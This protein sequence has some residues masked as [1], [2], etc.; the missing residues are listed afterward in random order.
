MRK[1]QA[2]AGGVV[3]NLLYKPQQCV[4]EAVQHECL[5]C[6]CCVASGGTALGGA[7]KT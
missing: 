1:V 7:R 6:N 4:G 2:S 5:I 3:L